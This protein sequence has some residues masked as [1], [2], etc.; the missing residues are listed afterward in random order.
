MYTITR[1]EPGHVSA[2]SAVESACAAMFPDSVLSPEE[3]ANV[4]PPDI[5]FAAQQAGNLW[6]TLAHDKPVGFALASLGGTAILKELDVH[7]SHSR[8][9]LGRKLI[10]AVAEAAAGAGFDYLYLT[11]F[12]NIQWNAPYYRR[13]GFVDAEEETLPAEVAN[14]LALQREAG[15]RNR[16]AMRIWVKQIRPD[17]DPT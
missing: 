11:T 16:V 3:K 1:A 12:A 8:R 2:L 17:A 4:T 13:L 14:D 10:Q 9:G 15:M 6:V 5:L 7:P